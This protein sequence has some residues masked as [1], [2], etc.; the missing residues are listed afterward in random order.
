M[1]KSDIEGARMQLW[2]L[3]F[4]TDADNQG[5]YAQYIEGIN[6]VLSFESED[7]ATRYALLLEAQDFPFPVVEKID[8]DE[9]KEFCLDAGYDL[10]VV[11]EGEL[12]IP[13]EK[14]VEQTDW[15]PDGS[16]KEPESEIEIMRR[17]LEGLL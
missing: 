4:S 10:G 5:I 7:D 1:L 12:A 16:N 6:T 8:E 14:N 2:V 15:Q 13:P 9:L 11:P 3:L 17:R